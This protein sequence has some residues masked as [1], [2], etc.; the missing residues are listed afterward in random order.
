M[1]RSRRVSR[2]SGPVSAAPGGV[3][4]A[5]IGLLD[6]GGR[7]GSNAAF[8]QA[9][10]QFQ[11][12]LISGLRGTCVDV[13]HVYA[14][15][16]VPS[17]PRRAKLLYWA[18]DVAFAGSVSA[19]LIGF[20]NFGPM[21]TLSGGLDL[22][23]RLLAW[24]WR[25]RARTRAIMQYNVNSPPGIVGVFAAWLTGSCFVPVIADVQVP[26]DGLLADNSLRRAD[27]WLQRR[28]LPL[29]DG[30]I[31]LT[32]R[33]A[34]D[35]ANRTPFLQME[36][37]VPDDMA[38]V[39]VAS[40]RS[41]DGS[42]CAEA[43]IL[44]YA[45]GLS[46]LKGIPLLLDAFSRVSGDSHQLWITG[47][48]PLQSTVEDAAARDPRIR[49]WGFQSRSAL[50][51]LYAQADVL[52]NPHSIRSA[53][54]R[55]LFPSKLIEYLATGTPV[56]TTCSTPEV[57]EQYGRFVFIA[58]DDSPCALAEAISGAVRLPRME[59]AAMGAAGREFVLMNKTWAVQGRRIAAF[60]SGVVQHRA[61]GE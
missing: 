3:A 23:P 13:T 39:Q 10:T 41:A 56:V 42:G 7:E 22:L 52:V 54:A 18:R 49:Y 35:F 34:E 45:G 17:F 58:A 59:L 46:K 14:L 24:A 6:V 27:F 25:E 38:E 8:S 9:G 11:E 29:C 40:R 31:L 1:L 61:A 44:M 5:F 19:T 4:C 48:G 2:V 28:T 21:K 30:L 50:L 60:I 53:S 57:G 51:D 55:Y 36:G 43:R 12:C 20:V 37:A 15:R 33:M 47:S 16:P 32:R 26:G